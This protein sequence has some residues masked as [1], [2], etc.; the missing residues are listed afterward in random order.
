[1]NKKKTYFLSI[2]MIILCALAIMF[3]FDAYHIDGKYD[4]LLAFC[5]SSIHIP[6]YVIITNTLLAILFGI[7]GTVVGIKLNK[8]FKWHWLLILLSVPL[9]FVI[10]L[11]CGILRDMFF[12][13]IV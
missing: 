6:K 9:S 4:G 5:F 2:F 12:L 7:W 8:Y 11:L 13:G 3:A 1:M 10:L